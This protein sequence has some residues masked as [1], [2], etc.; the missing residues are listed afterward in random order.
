MVGLFEAQ[1]GFMD[2]VTL[3]VPDD[4]IEILATR[5]VRI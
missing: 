5:L 4:R 1:M 3:K 2:P